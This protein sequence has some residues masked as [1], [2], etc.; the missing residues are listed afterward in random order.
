ME[1]LPFFG[2]EPCE[3]LVPK[4][5]DEELEIITNV[6]ELAFDQVGCRMIQQR[7]E[8]KLNADFVSALL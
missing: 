4:L 5:S 7:L 6:Y 3:R 1:D 2:G 8:E